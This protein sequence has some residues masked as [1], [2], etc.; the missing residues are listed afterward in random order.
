M[1]R[2]KLIGGRGITMEEAIDIR[3]TVFGSASAP[4]RGE[5]TRTGLS[6]IHSQ[7]DPYP[8][9]LRSPK[10]ATR[11]LQ[12]VVQA[13]LIKYFIFDNR[14]KE[15]SVPLDKL[16]KPTESEQ[17]AAMWNSLSEIL[18]NV[19]DKTKVNVCLPG[20]SPHISHS[21]SYFQDNITEKLSIFEFNKL[22]D[23]QIFIKRYVFFFTDDPSPGA[24]LLLYSAVW[25]R[26]F[27]NIRND[28]DC[29]K[30]A[31]LMGNYEEGSLNIVTL[32]LSGRATPYLHNGVVYVGDEDHY[33]MPQFGILC[34]SRV[35]LLIWDGEGIN[36]TSRQPGSRLKTPGLPI[37]VTCC[38]GHYGIVF[39]SNRELLRNYH[40]EKRF[41]LHHYTNA[42]IFVT[43][44]VDNRGQD[45]EEVGQ[46]Q[47]QRQNSKGEIKESDGSNLQATPLEKLI[48]TKWAD[49]KI[50]FH[51]QIEP[52]KLNL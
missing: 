30:G 4:P 12:S 26:G 1:S 33:A 25:T 20:D 49:G 7:N 18:W 44:T 23:L 51:H 31:H 27:E 36:V 8:F 16:L 2:P 29:P 45:D 11:G 42:G 41:E 46:P 50:T 21:Q 19:G 34:R 5:W 3:V 35:G 52:A 9:G 14:P 47:L 22:E 17:V 48:H 13:F 39:N 32:L 40:A 43:M 28:L 37:W 6:Y 15:K 24:L 10:N 38:M